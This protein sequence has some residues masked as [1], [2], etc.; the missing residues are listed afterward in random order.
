MRK[1]FGITAIIVVNLMTTIAFAADDKKDAKAGPIKPAAVNLGRPVDYERDVYPMLESNCIACHNVAIDEGKL[2]LEEVELMIKGGK[3]GAALVPKEPDKSLVYKLAARGQKPAMPPLPNEMDAHALTPDELGILR[4]WIIEGATGGSGDDVKMVNWQPLPSDVQSLYAISLSPWA[5]FAAAGRANQIHV[6]DLGT[7]REVANLKDPHLQSLQFNGQAMYPKGAAH[8]DFVHSLAFSPDGRTLASGG[9]R[10]VKLWQRPEDLTTSKIEG[11]GSVI[12]TVVSPNGQLAAFASADNSVKLVNLADGKTTHTLTGATGPVNGLSFSQDGSLL[13]GGS[14]DKIVRA[15]KTAD[16]A[17]AWQ[18][19]TPAAIHDVLVTKDGGQILTAH[20]DNLVRLWP[21]GAVPTGD[22]VKPEEANKPVREFKGHGKPVTSLAWLP[23][24]TQFVSGSDDNT[25]RQ[26][27]LNNG[28]QIRSFNHGSPVRDVAVRP[29]G[30]FFAAVGQN[31]QAKLYDANGKAIATME[32]NL[33]AQHAVTEATEAKAVIDSQVKFADAA[34]KAAEKNLTDREAAVKSAKEAQTKAVEALKD[35][36]KKFTDAETKL[37]AAKDE[38][39]KKA[40]DAKLQK[41]VA[42]AQ[43]EFDRQQAE[44]KKATDAKTAADRSVKLAEKAIPKAKERVETEKTELDEKKKQQT[45]AT[46]Q[47]ADAKKAEQAARK[48]FQSVAFSADG[49]LLATAGE[50]QAIHLWN[51]ENGNALESLA[52]HSGA[53]SSLRFLD[54]D[55]LLSVSADQTARVWDTTPEWK[56]IAT[57]GGNAD[58]PT[59]VTASP[60]SDRVLSLD[61]SHD[62]KKLAAGSGEPSR[63]GGIVIWDLEKQSVAKSIEDAHSDTVLG[64]EFNRDGSQIVSGGA[65]KFVKVF[66]VEDGQFVRSFEGHTHHVMDV[67]WR[68]DGQRLASAG[69]DNVIKVW[70]VETGEQVTTI[71]GHGKQVT[72]LQFVGTSDNVITGGG[73]KSVRLYTASNRRQVRSF[74]GATDYVY[75]VAASRDGKLFV[76]GGEDGV[77]R[78][79]NDKGQ[80][81]LTFAPPEPAT[82]PKTQAAK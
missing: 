80:A 28:R 10:V 20:A 29:D 37:K 33:A 68:A 72:S 17:L 40:D 31:G 39:A 79:W 46:T 71:T 73:D 45:A 61:F 18:R 8:R 22:D 59:D 54:A 7:G 63:S 62:G 78:V 51:S 81:V 6:Y 36:Q 48:P 24:A 50:D 4:Q 66:N 35:P 57:L 21:A 64:L 26:W 30:K 76:A 14:A 41:K 19:E 27:D 55:R 16:G 53:V 60:I 2:N 77:L 49:K 38:L 1:N 23:N 15:W 25:F 82:D 9:Y 13:V 11:L 65:D 67:S 70:N 43:K 52:G 5:R 58:E 74:G 69:A 42:D 32:G 47:E 34:L 44:L 3:S 56:L 12:A 75:S